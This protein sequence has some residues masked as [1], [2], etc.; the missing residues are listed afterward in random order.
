M[1]IRRIR[2][3]VATHNWFAVGIDLAIVMLGVFLGI[4][5]SNWNESRIE[6]EEGRSYR[7]RLIAELDFNTRQ[8]RQQSAYYRQV[9][10]HGLAAL[11]SLRSDKIGDPSQ[12]L[13]DAVQLT[14]VDTSPGKSYIYNEMVSSGLVN[15]LGDEAVQQAASDYYIQVSENDRALL[16]SH[17][18]RDI[19][20]GIVPYSIQGEIQ[21][22]CGDRNVY[23][24]KRIIGV[25]LP[26]S[27]P[28]RLDPSLAAE[29]AMQVRNEPGIERDLVRYLGS[30]HEKLGSLD[31]TLNLATQLRT[32]LHRPAKVS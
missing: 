2:E 15:R 28:V 29:S 8:H 31:D 26:D 12:F 19:A 24:R 21:V 23:H 14:Q 13:I 6:A 7:A 5:A 20:R 18:F 27:C 1:V 10:G 16:H 22:N 4:Q 32:S 3:H 17:P 25:R 30:I 9:L 11:A